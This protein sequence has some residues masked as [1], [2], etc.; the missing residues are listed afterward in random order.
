MTIQLVG[1]NTV[2]NVTTEI[3]VLEHSSSTGAASLT[4]TGDGS[5]T[6]D[7]S[8]KGIWVQSNGGGATL[9]INNPKVEAERGNFSGDA[10]VMVQAGDSSG[11]SLTVDDGSLTATG[12]GSESGIHF[13]FGSNT[14]SGASSLTVS[15]N[16]I[17]RA[18][19]GIYDNSSANIQIKTDDNYSGGIVWNGKDGTV[20]SDVEL[21]EDLKIDNRRGREPDAG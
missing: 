20:Y 16:T 4:V 17:V 18:S 8:S 15:G 9:E 1:N 13:Q 21:Q 12:T 3:Y 10:G 2:E 14:G 7:G 5:L 19:G 11:A 6:A